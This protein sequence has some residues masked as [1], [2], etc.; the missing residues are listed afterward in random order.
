MKRLKG[1]QVPLAMNYN[2]NKKELSWSLNG[3]GRDECCVVIN[4]Q[5]NR[6]KGREAADD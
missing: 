6:S 2:P 3:P 1:I 5:R 4:A